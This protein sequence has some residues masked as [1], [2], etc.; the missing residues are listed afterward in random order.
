MSRNQHPRWC[1]QDH[2]CQL[3]EHRSG[4]VT[5]GGNGVVSMV[6]S[7]VQPGE[8][9]SI[10]LIVSVRLSG[11]SE[12]AYANQAARLMTSIAKTVQK[13]LRTR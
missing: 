2:R 12:R 4:F 8:T 11:D 10:E 3:G 1:E 6:L 5:L 7:L 9:P 13:E